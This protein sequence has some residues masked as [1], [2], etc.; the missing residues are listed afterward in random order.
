[1]AME[2]LPGLNK[3]EILLSELNSHYLLTNQ[4]RSHILLVLEGLKQACQ[5]EIYNPDKTGYKSGHENEYE[6]NTTD[7]KKTIEDLQE[8]FQKLNLPYHLD[9]NHVQEED[10]MPAHTVAEFLIGKD[11]ET[12]TK[13]K[14]VSKEVG[15]SEDAKIFDIPATAIDAWNNGT[16]KDLETLPDDIRNS[17]V[18]QFIDFALSE[19][20]WKEEIEFVRRRAD[21]IKN[22]APEL[23]A[24]IAASE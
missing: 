6:Q 14:N 2:K 9:I 4:D 24:K 13:L 10:G 23:Y 21:A 7:F 3:R 20:H 19:D 5:I 18:F 22:L 15:G 16:T 8:L 11:Q 17:E 1:M 12:L